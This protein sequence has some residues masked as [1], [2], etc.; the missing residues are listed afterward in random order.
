[1]LKEPSPAETHSHR[2]AETI[3]AFRQSADAD[4]SEI[5]Y[6]ISHAG[7]ML[8][9]GGRVR[10]N[11]ID[12]DELWFAIFSASENACQRLDL[13]YPREQIRR[14]FRA[15]ANLVEYWA[16]SEAERGGWGD[17]LPD[18]RDA[19]RIFQNDCHNMTLRV[20]IETRAH[21]R[22]VEMINAMGVAANG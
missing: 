8:S 13:G 6:F 16:S 10:L 1:M 11:D 15:F 14:G 3:K 9:L 21:R 2:V 20:Q 5:A 18:A 17:R 12:R 7:Y 4:D 22:R 19:A